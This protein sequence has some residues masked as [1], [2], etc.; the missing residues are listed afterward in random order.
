MCLDWKQEF[1]SR[2]GTIMATPLVWALWIVSGGYVNSG[3]LAQVDVKAYFN[4]VQECSRIGKIIDDLA[5]TNN[6]GRPIHRIR[7]Q[8]IQSGYII[9]QSVPQPTDNSVK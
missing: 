3:Y 7:Y 4:T 6:D 2:E 8:C 9:P 5:V 1:S